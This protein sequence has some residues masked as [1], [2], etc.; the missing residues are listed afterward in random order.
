MAAKGK[1]TASKSGGKSVG[2]SAGKSSKSKRGAPPPISVSRPK[3]WGLIAGTVAVVLFAGAV[4]GY[5]V[6]QL[7]AQASETP[8]ARAGDA[9][10]IE[11]ISVVNGLTRNHV[12]TPVAYAQTP[13]IGGDHDQ[14]WADCA[15]TVYASPIRNENA[16]HA[17]EH[18]AIWVTYQPGLP[19]A[20]VDTLKAKVNGVDGMMMSPYEGLKTKIS[21]QSWGHQ[22]FVD[23]VDDPRIDRFITDLRL[24]EVTTPEFGASCADPAFKENPRA[25]EPTAAPPT[26]APPTGAAPTSPAP[27]SARP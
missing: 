6:F 16:V 9:A 15:G 1:S 20:E 19:A 11:G 17:L 22:L 2:K 26:S 12:Q 27:T 18:G 13:P 14:E 24:N 8:E 4:I 5:A 10:R 23:R 25:P 3:P 7:R 21:L